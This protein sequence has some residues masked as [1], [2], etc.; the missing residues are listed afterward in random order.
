MDDERI[1]LWS[2]CLDPILSPIS[3]LGFQGR[4]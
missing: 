4:L 2:G 1:E 3:E